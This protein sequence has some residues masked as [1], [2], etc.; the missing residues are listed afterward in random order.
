MRQFLQE[1]HK[2][3]REDLRVCCSCK[4]FQKDTGK[5]SHEVVFEILGADVPVAALSGP[6]FAGEVIKGQPSAAVIASADERFANQLVGYFHGG[7]FR[8]Y[9]SRD[10][11]GVEVGGA[12]K[13]VLAIAAGVASGLGFGANTLAALVTRG[14]AEMSRLG[15]A[16]GGESATFMG[17]AG[18]GDLMLTCT[19]DQSRNR[20]LGIALARG[21]TLDE[22]YVAIGQVVE[23]ARSAPE[24]CSVADELGL[25]MPITQQVA[26]L[27]RGE[28]RPVE[29]VEALLARG[30]KGELTS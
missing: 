19:D 14:L 12:V 11:I 21:A 16:M 23:G 29:A 6:T 17:L 1:L 15:V 13:N 5:L 24:V 18:L 26:A 20:R 3:T 22:A 25:E 2:D 27:L 8:A 4:G 10:L 9:S 30:P 28:C 7:S